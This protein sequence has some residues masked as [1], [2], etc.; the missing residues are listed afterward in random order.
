[1]KRKPY[2]EKAT[3][4]AATAAVGS[5]RRPAKSSMEEKAQFSRQPIA[6]E[7]YASLANVLQPFRHPHDRYLHKGLELGGVG[8]GGVTHEDLRARQQVVLHV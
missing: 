6:A 2:I 8:G 7:L 3:P 5:G 4:T 1:M